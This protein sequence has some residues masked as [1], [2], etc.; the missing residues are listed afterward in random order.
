MLLAL[1]GTIYPGQEAEYRKA[2]ELT[3]VPIG[4]KSPAIWQHQT[5]RDSF[6][7]IIDLTAFGIRTRQVVAPPGGLEFHLIVTDTVAGLCTF[8]NYRAEREVADIFP[9]AGRRTLLLPPSSCENP[10]ILTGLLQFIREAPLIQEASSDLDLLITCL[11]VEAERH[12]RQQL[13]GIHGVQLLDRANLGVSFWSG[14]T[15]KVPREADRNRK[16][17]CLFQMKPMCV[18]YQEGFG[19]PA[20]PTAVTLEPGSNELVL[21]PPDGFRNRWGQATVVDLACDLWKEFPRDPAVARQMRAGAWLSPYG[22]SFELD[23]RERATDVQFNLPTFWD[24]LQAYFGSRGFEVRRSAPAEYSEA[25]L[26]LLGGLEQASVLASVP[27]YQILDALSLKSSKKIAQRIV[28]ALELSGSAEEQLVNVLRDAEVIPEL[29]KAPRT[30]NE[31]RAFGEKKVILPLLEQLSA[32]RIVKRGFHATCPS[33]RTPN[34]YPLQGIGESL[35]CPGCATPFL[36]PVEQHK[37]SGT[38]LIWEYT[39]NSLVNRVMDQDVLPGVLAVYHETKPDCAQPFV[40]GVELIPSG[41]NNPAA[42]FDYLFAREHQLFAGECKSGTGLSEKDMETARVAATLGVKE[43]AFCTVRRFSEESTMLV[44]NLQ[45]ELGSG[46]QAMTIKMFSGQE[47][48]GG[49]LP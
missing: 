4:F 13:T 49:V 7:S 43:F 27:T 22:L 46:S 29:K 6:G 39:L 5:N 38:E 47:L 32:A 44:K 23:V 12:L 24:M 37:G 26:S 20:H 14:H 9:S 30:L 19:P 42:E 11:D 31:L 25:L 28:K 16:I 45:A 40:A 34:W 3:G 36:L 17:K 35:V 15:E 2:F 10:E 33:C 41:S 18:S 48:L 8:W 1:F 21:D